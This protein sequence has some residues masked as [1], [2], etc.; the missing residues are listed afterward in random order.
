[1]VTRSMSKHYASVGAVHNKVNLQEEL[2]V[3]KQWPTSS[4]YCI[5]GPPPGDSELRQ[6]MTRSFN[7]VITLGKD[8]ALYKRTTEQKIFDSKKRDGAFVDL[9]PYLTQESFTGVQKELNEISLNLSEDFLSHQIINI[10]EVDEE[11]GTVTI[12]S[13][14][15][16]Q[17]TVTL[18]SG[19]TYFLDNKYFSNNE[20]DFVSLTEPTQK[21]LC[22]PRIGLK[23]DHNYFKK[24]EIEESLNIE[25]NSEELCINE[26]VAQNEF[27]IENALHNLLVNTA[28]LRCLVCNE[29]PQEMIDLLENAKHNS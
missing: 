3:K 4:A 17:E 2:L 26:N 12:Q 29:I 10:I 20:V 19:Q 18:Y 9:T 16:A 5:P 24:M 15:N 13:K 23:N 6:V 22:D 14:A 7:H 21:V 25:E 1:M 28:T 27:S 8:V 11:K